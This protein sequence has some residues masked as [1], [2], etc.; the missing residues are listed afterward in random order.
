MYFKEYYNMND[1]EYLEIA[2]A[3]D[4]NVYKEIKEE[5]FRKIKEIS[6]FAVDS[7]KSKFWYNEG[8]PRTWN[9]LEESDIDHLFTKNKNE[10]VKVF[11]IF[12]SY[13]LIKNALRCNF[14]K[15]DFKTLKSK[16]QL[17]L[18][19]SNLSSLVEKEKGTEILFK[20][21]DLHLMKIKFEE[22]IAI[23]LE[24][25]KRR[26]QSIFQTNMPWWGWVLIV[27]F[28]YDDVLRLIG[29]YW[30]IPVILLLASYSLLNMVG[31]SYLPKHLI[32]KV[33]EKAMTV[34]RKK[35]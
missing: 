34:F 15:K 35:N 3:I 23:I 18:F 30:I 29:S 7:F 5:F 13:D 28:G 32:F 8:V 6:S 17:N 25:A 27:Y 12:K 9:K 16:D 22:G 2:Q 19:L 11:E 24:D 21:E 33:Q 14:F 1:L 31:L 26:Q 10:V 4:D 20:S